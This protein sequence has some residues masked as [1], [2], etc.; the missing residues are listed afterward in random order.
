MST[1]SPET[2]SI[3]DN[4]V[5]ELARTQSEINIAKAEV[6]NTQ[7]LINAAVATPKHKPDTLLDPWAFRIFVCLNI[8]L[9]ALL[10]AFVAIGIYSM[11]N[12]WG[13]MREGERI[14]CVVIMASLVVHFA[15]SRVQG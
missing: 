10:I 15:S 9:A 4:A 8:V 14:C 5:A 2:K 1:I 7:R 13:K 12:G 3:L 6:A 11:I